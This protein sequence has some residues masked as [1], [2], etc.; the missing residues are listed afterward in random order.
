MK[1]AHSELTQNK[2]TLTIN[3]IID[4]SVFGVLVENHIFIIKKIYTIEC[5]TKQK[6]TILIYECAANLTLSIQPIY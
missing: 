2:E 3:I 5:D 1:T 4:S 6:K